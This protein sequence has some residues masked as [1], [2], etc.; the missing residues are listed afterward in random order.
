MALSRGWLLIEQ[1]I[2]KALDDNS[3]NDI[4][5]NDNPKNDNSKNDNSK[6]DNSIP[7]NPKAYSSID[8]TSF[9]QILPQLDPDD[10][11]HYQHV[12]MITS[13]AHVIKLFF[14]DVIFRVLLFCVINILLILN[15]GHLGHNYGPITVIVDKWPCSL[16]IQLVFWVNYE[17]F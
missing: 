9:L 4:S 15:Y 17:D 2:Y 5:K 16:R 8:D 3:K 11:L 6:N 7:V 1:P 10:K 14:T 12:A 13:G